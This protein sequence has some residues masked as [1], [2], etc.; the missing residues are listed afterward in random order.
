MEVFLGL[1]VIQPY[2]QATYHLK[3][4]FKSNIVIKRGQ[5]AYPT[6][7]LLA[8]MGGYLGLFLGYSM[9]DIHGFFKK[10]CTTYFKTQKLSKIVKPNQNN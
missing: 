1:P 9:M 2:G 6:E 7:S 8:E 4:Y 5:I 3:M 10:I